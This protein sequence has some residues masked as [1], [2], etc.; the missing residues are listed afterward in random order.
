MFV[1]ELLQILVPFI[2]GSFDVDDIILNTIESIIGTYLAI[3]ISINYIKNPLHL[4]VEGLSNY[5]LKLP[6]ISVKIPPSACAPAS[7]YP[8]LLS[9]TVPARPM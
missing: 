9:P 4:K 2:G 8:K 7:G 6:A 1:I 3:Y 5:Y